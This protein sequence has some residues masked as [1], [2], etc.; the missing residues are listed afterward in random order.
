M[1]V[2]ITILS[3]YKKCAACGSKF[4]AER[5]EFLNESGVIL[6]EM[7]LCDICKIA[8]EQAIGKPTSIPSRYAE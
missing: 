4:G 1:R 2:T 3:T 6:H 7:I 5:Y 8:L